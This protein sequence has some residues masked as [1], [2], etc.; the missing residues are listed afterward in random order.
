MIESERPKI[1]CIFLDP[2]GTHGKFTV[3]PLDRGY[4]HTIGNALRRVLLSSLQG[5]A[6]TS[7]KIDGALHEFTTIPGVKEDVTEIALNLKGL[8]FKL[9]GD[10]VKTAYIDA[11]KE[12]NVT[13][14]DI[15]ADSDIEIVNGDM[16]IATLNNKARL[17]IE[18]TLERGEG[19]VPLEQNKQRHQ[20]IGVIPM[21]SIFTP[22][23]KVNYTV[24]NTRV[25]QFTEFDKLT[26][27]IWTDGTISPEESLSSAAKI[28]GSHL[29][30]FVGLTEVVSETEVVVEGKLSEK[31]RLLE[32]T[33]EELDL[34][35]RSYNCLKRAAISNVRDLLDK[36]EDEM[37]KIRN[38]GKKSLEEVINKVQELGL[39]LKAV[40]EE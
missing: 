9:E 40:E 29:N 36:S 35:V 3:E 21:D 25:G 27:E 16:H 30:L 17:H 38:M 12:G 5:T 31:E 8:I 10:Q 26:F 2:K 34:S 19:Y 13:A 37:I 20:D 23:K 6:V 4:G 22:V 18:L 7:M 28:L 15:K 11:D 24:E 14:A 1:Q 33:I 32:T 39:A